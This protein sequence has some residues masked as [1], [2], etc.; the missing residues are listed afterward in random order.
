MLHRL[1][2]RL[3]GD[4]VEHHALD[5]LVLERLVFLEHLEHVPRN[6][7]AFAIRVGG[8]DQL[9]GTLQGAGDVIH[10]LLRL[11]IDL[12]QHAKIVVRVDRTVFRGE[13]PDMAKRSQDLIA[14][15]EVLIDRL[16]L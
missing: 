8:K 16:R 1:A 15:A 4:G 10:P 7:F 2:H 6:R 3:L 9:V 14:G 11:R 12:P 13:V 5:F